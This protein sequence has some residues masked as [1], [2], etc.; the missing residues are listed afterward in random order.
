VLGPYVA[1]SAT[2]NNMRHADS[3]MLS[4]HDDH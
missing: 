1:A 4:R 2:P 3:D